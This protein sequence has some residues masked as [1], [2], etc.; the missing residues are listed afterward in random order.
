MK[1]G[2]LTFVNAPNF[3]AIL[4]AYASQEFIQSLKID[5]NLINY[6]P[7]AK[8]SESC[9][10]SQINSILNKF[11]NLRH[12]IKTYQR[13]K[14]SFK[15]NNFKSE[16]LK[17]SKQKYYGEI[18]EL[19]ENYDTIIAGSDQIWNTD[20]SFGSK[21]FFLDFKTNARK[22]GYAVSTGRQNLSELDCRMIHKYINNFE[23]LSV[24][25]ESLKKYLKQ[26]EKK[27]CKLVCDPVFLRKKLE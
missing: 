11:L 25:E 14:K 4:Q 10:T 24:R 3:G 6:T 20:L 13:K 8:N 1:V 22:T 27:E 2:I 16:F 18:T 19:K 21:S 9:E 5:A 23:T 26:S 17:I 15:L 7:P 12:P